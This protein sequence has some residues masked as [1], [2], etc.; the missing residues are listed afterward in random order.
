M[1]LCNGF[2]FF[3]YLFMTSDPLSSGNYLTPTA[4]YNETAKNAGTLS[5][6]RSELEHRSGLCSW[7][8]PYITAIFTWSVHSIKN[9]TIFLSLSV[10]F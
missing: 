10:Q 1:Y 2:M 6:I 9:A 7:P 5:R 4:A 3:H 8:K